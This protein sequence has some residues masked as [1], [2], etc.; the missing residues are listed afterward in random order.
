[1]AERRR[2]GCTGEDWVSHSSLPFG[3]PLSLVK[4][5]ARQKVIGQRK[6]DA[7]PVA[8][9]EWVDAAEVVEEAAPE[10]KSKKRKT[11]RGE[12]ETKPARKSKKS[13][14]NE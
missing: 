8:F 14:P 13:E 2:E 5:S 9:L 3:S 11:A 6:S 4:P 10:K 1:M 12:A 7:A